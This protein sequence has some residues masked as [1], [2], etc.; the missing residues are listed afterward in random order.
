MEASEKLIKQ[1]G[2]FVSSL[3]DPQQMQLSI[4]NSHLIIIASYKAFT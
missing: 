2:S 3:N 4:K 1:K